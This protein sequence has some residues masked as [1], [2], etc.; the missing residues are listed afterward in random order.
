VLVSRVSQSL[1]GMPT[2][3]DGE[4]LADGVTR[5]VPPFDEFEVGA[6]TSRFLGGFLRLLRHSWPTI[7]CLIV[8]PYRAPHCSVSPGHR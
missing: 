2:I 7:L 3:L 8:C 4:R 5:Y 1:Q 6:T